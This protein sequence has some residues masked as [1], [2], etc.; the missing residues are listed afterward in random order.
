MTLVLSH[1][2][3]SLLPDFTWIKSEPFQQKRLPVWPLSISVLRGHLG[4]EV[5]CRL[6]LMVPGGLIVRWLKLSAKGTHM[7]LD[8]DWRD[9]WVSWVGKDIVLHLRWV[10]RPRL[11]FHHMTFIFMY[12]GA[13]C[14]IWANA[15]SRIRCRSLSGNCHTW[16]YRQC[17]WMNMP[18]SFDYV[19]ESKPSRQ[20][21][22]YC[23]VLL[24]EAL[25][26]SRFNRM[27]AKW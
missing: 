18:V 1:G 27:A 14:S 5:N 2:R 15:P 22:E 20:C 10:E 8:H 26:R 12:S 24:L 23:N 17:R 25:S 9:G 4:M 7:Q 21:V 19:C 13:V 6:P 3:E 16:A 11:W